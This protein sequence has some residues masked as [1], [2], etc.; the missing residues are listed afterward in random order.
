MCGTAVYYGITSHSM[1]MCMLGMKMWMVPSIAC[2][3]VHGICVRASAC[4]VQCAL[5]VQLNKLMYVC[6]CM[7]K[8]ECLKEF[9]LCCMCRRGLTCIVRAMCVSAHAYMAAHV[10]VCVR[11]CLLMETLMVFTFVRACAWH[12]AW[13]VCV[14]LPVV[15]VHA[16]MDARMRV[17]AC[18]ACA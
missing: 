6:D 4:M 2:M 9:E 10:Y 3:R 16:R 8:I 7:C 14:T 15:H 17:C 13:H 5:C 1:S 18:R 12:L 11:A